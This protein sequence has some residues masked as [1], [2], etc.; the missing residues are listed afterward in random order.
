[1]IPKIIHYC[2]FG[3]NSKPKDVLR[4][5]DSWKQYCPDYQIIEWNEDNF[6]INA[7]CSFVEDAYKDAKWAFVSDYARLQIVY[8]NG[9]I[10]L[11]TDVELLKSLDV[12]L[13]KGL[14]FM[15]FETIDWVASGLGF[16]AE[17]GDRII[18][19]M[20]KYYH[21]LDFNQVDPAKVACPIINTE[22]LKR[23]GL[24]LNNRLQVVGKLQILPN[25]FLC[26]ENIFTG[27]SKYTENTVSIHH[28]SASWMSNEEKHKMRLIV[29]I[30]RILPKR[31]VSVIRKIYKINDKHKCK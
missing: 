31:T 30:K 20:M 6:N 17:K 11:D 18:Y 28:Y 3:R 5:I 21:T 10:Y 16:A 14:G 29:A 9:G 24:N 25:D 7:T 23:H 22:V 12:L 8:E 1:M 19:E 26:P 27:E 15:G 2:W 13:D 4:C